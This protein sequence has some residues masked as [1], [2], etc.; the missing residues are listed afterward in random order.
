MPSEGIEKIRGN[1]TSSAVEHRR[2]LR[3]G[4]GVARKL[5]GG[6]ATRNHLLDCVRRKASIIGRRQRGR[7]VLGRGHFAAWSLAAPRDYFGFRRERRGLV[8]LPHGGVVD[9]LSGVWNH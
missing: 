2:K 5:T 4:D 8:Y 1:S 7:R 6:S 9:L 3:E